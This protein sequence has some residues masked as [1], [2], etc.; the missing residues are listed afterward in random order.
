MYRKWYVWTFFRVYSDDILELMLL[1]III[2]II[3]LLTFEMGQILFSYFASFLYNPLEFLRSHLLGP[4]RKQ[5][6]RCI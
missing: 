5:L 1:I 2:I 4:N 6:S 3:S